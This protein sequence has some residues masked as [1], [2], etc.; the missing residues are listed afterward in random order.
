[1]IEIVIEETV[2]VT[3]SGNVKE[4]VTE[5][6]TAR[7]SVEDTEAGHA[8]KN[9]IGTVIATVTVIVIV[10]GKTIGINFIIYILCINQAFSQI[11]FSVLFVAPSEGLQ[12][13]CQQ[14]NC[15]AGSVDCAC[16]LTL[17]VGSIPNRNS[18]CF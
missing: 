15:V 14:R 13:Y 10:T 6:V 16:S 3:A 12:I 9:V 5:I 8:R 7:K 2:T 11:I 1:M 18:G 17:F 4:I